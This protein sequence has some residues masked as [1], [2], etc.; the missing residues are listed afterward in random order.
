MVREFKLGY[1]L[2]TAFGNYIFIY[3]NTIGTIIS[4]GKCCDSFLKAFLN[5]TL[6]YFTIERILNIPLKKPL[7]LNFCLVLGCGA[8]AYACLGNLFK[9]IFFIDKLTMHYFKN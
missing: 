2:K 3:L 6:L 9:D 5:E 7:F 1:H 4:G 8:T